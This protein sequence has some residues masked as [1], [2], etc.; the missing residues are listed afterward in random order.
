MVVSGTQASRGRRPPDRRTAELQVLAPRLPGRRAL[1]VQR[2]FGVDSTADPVDNQRGVTVIKQVM[3]IAAA[4]AVGAAALG[5]YV[6]ASD[7]GET[8]ALEQGDR[9]RRAKASLEGFQEVPAISTTGSGR[10]DLRIDDD[11]QTIEFELSY[12][13]LEGIAPFVPG[14][15]VTA[16][17]IHLG[18]T[19]TNGG[20]SAFF[21]GGGG[22]PACPPSGTV[23]GTVTAADIVGPA[24]QGIDPGEATAFAELVR[25]IRAG[26]TYVNVHTTR[27]P[28]GEIRGRIGS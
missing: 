8:T 5:G 24:A 19:G 26:Y 22:K 23:T 15:V 14:G 25:A 11:A 10:L 27:W 21:C 13:D 20:V 9:A 28:T 4:V 2:R 6:S 7:Q 3:S 1:P 17:H 12:G 18:A 16:A